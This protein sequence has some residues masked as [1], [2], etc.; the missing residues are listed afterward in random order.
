MT[1]ENLNLSII[2]RC[3]RNKGGL[4]RC[5]ES[6]DAPVEIVIGAASDASF[7]NEMK[8]KGYVVAPH[9]YGN[10]SL[11]AEAGVEAA[12]HN[13]IIMMDA[14][15]TFGPGAIAII[16]QA[17]TAGHLLVQPKV[18]FL[19]D[20]RF[21]SQV[22]SNA[23][24]HENRFRPKAYSPGLGLKRQELRQAIGVNGHIYNPNVLYGDDGYLDQKAKEKGIGVY[25]AENAQI[26]HDPVGLKH[27]LLAAFHFGQ[28]E[29]Q[30]EQ[31]PTGI[32]EQVVQ[33]FLTKDS[34]QYFR[35][36]REEYGKD[37]A[38]FMMLW[39]LIYVAGFSYESGI[40]DK[41]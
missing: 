19:T 17:L 15:S 40:H 11:A 38:L 5:I 34:Q 16:N 26:Y 22:I 28:G 18:T 25:I 21:L 35:S 7:L 32:W 37:T 1:K 31:D 9:V 6:V 41:A 10:W 3:G 12:S 23:R 39:R 8:N 30:L 33:A 27:E 2:I 4:L 36:A 14:D 29:Y 20:Q 24:A 13:R